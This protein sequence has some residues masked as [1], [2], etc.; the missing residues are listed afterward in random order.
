[1]VRADGI[2]SAVGDCF[3]QGL[4]ILRTAQ[5]W[6]LFAQCANRRIVGMGEIV[7]AGFNVNL[8]AVTSEPAGLL[9]GLA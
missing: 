2:D 9:Q 5:G 6:V 4:H 1:M 3:P 8:V 7:G